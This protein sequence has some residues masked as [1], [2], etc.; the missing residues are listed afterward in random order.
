MKKLFCLLFGHGRGRIS[1][2]D[3]HVLCARC[4]KILL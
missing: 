4:K 3:G 2:E 1:T